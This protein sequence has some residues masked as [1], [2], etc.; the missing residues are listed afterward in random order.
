MNFVDIDSKTFTSFNF[1]SA[2]AI[3][4]TLYFRHLI[5]SCRM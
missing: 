1:A 2:S 5:L 3:T 4:E